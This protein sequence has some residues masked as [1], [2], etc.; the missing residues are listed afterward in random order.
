MYDSIMV[1][2]PPTETD[3]NV[4]DDLGDASSSFSEREE[5]DD[6]LG[7]Y[8]LEEIGEDPMIEEK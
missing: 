6:E 7:M 2:D 1:E 4:I 8:E 3:E 5:I